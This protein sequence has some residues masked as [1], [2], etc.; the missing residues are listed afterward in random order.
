MPVLFD[1]LRTAPLTELQDLGRFGHMAIG[2]SRGG[3]M[4]DYA[5]AQNN[6]LLGNDD[7]AAQ[8]EIAPGGLILEARCDATIAVSG[9]YAHP[10]LNGI[11][12]INGHSHHIRAGDRLQ[13]G[14]PRHGQYSY[15][16]VLGGFVADP[17]LGSRATTTRLAL[18]AQA[19]RV[20]SQ[21]HIADTAARHI[22]LQGAKRAAMPDYRG[23]WLD[24][25]PAWQYADFSDAARASFFSQP[26]RV[27]ASDRMGVQL[28]GQNAL[29]PPTHE[30][31]SE[32]ILPGAIQINHSGQPIVL[33][34]DAQTLGG[35]HK[36]GILD[37]ASRILL[38]QS[39]PGK[40]LRFRLHGSA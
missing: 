40:I 31:L 30:L 4:D 23:E 11:P 16:A 10:T 29:S 12:L 14:Y 36:I 33:Q 3:A 24:V 22:P 20:G 8:L 1:I 38:A 37:D 7:N 26:W 27:V 34:K 35:Y 15:L 28:A 39:P 21:L 5:F 25:I 2:I 17:V 19:L 18:A 6:A 9:A 13:W 32:G